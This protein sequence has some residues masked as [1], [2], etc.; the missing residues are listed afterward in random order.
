MSNFRFKEFEIGQDRCAMKVGTDGVLLGAWVDA[1]GAERILDIGT[2]TGLIALMLAQK[3]AAARITGI[4]IDPSA[5]VQALENVRASPWSDRIAVIQVSA[6]E[7]GRAQGREFDL[8]VS[9]PPYFD[10][11]LLSA[12]QGRNRVRHTIDLSY[13]DLVKAVDG[14]LADEGRFYVILPARAA[15]GFCRIGRYFGVHC[16]GM[17]KISTKSGKPVSRVILEFRRQESIA[18]EEE[19][20]IQG[21]HDSR[22]SEAYRKLT[23][24]FYLNLE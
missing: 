1:A 17:L 19:L 11:A 8:I 7:F 3:S 6:Q 21:D 22:W 23:A 15:E 16:T 10:K 13:G 9:N 18:W 12:D 2:G 4:D 5:T 20:T 24:P 14:L